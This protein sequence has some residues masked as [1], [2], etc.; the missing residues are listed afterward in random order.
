MKTNREH[1]NALIY[2]LIAIA[3]FGALSMIMSRQG[4]TGETAELS[5]QKAQLYATE[6][7]AYA[8]QAKSAVD[9]MLFSGANIEELDFTLPGP[10]FEAGTT[11]DKIKRVYH[12]DGGGLSAGKLPV[13][14][15]S[16]QGSTPVAGWY[17]GRFNNVEWTKSTDTDVILTAYGIKREIC[18]KL[19]EKLTGAAT[20]PTLGAGA[21]AVLVDDQYHV[22]GSNADLTTVTP[23]TPI[24]AACHKR[25]SLCV[26]DQ[27][28]DIY[29][30][31]TVI[32]DR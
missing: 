3:L 30:F 12:P 10:G 9:Q 14:A 1:G 26:K 5:S 13:E 11:A 6:I 21:A 8:A 27:A 7:G 28:S 24:C 20:I 22:N 29:A 19:N 18:E 23:G 16:Y 4:D 17:M 25:A 31:Y 32:A 2:V 15:V